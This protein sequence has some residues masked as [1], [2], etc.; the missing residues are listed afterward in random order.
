M[1]GITLKEK[2]F[3]NMIDFNK[4]E[5][6]KI[7][8]SEDQH[9]EIIKLPTSIQKTLKK[10]GI[11]TKRWRDNEITERAQEYLTIKNPAR[12]HA[13]KSK[14][15]NESVD[16]TIPLPPKDSFI[17]NLSRNYPYRTNPPFQILRNGLP[18]WDLH[19]ILGMIFPSTIAYR[20]V[21]EVEAL[22]SHGVYDVQLEHTA[23]GIPNITIQSLP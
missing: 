8:R 11:I 13:V 20:I 10:N 7:M 23:S 2:S 1:T 18:I 4:H 6:Q 12:A 16:S 15:E 21:N 3:R 9:A 22:G 17:I 14:V 19:R 5:L